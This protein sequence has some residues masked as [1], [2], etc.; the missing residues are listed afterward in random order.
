MLVETIPEIYFRSADAIPRGVTLHMVTVG[1]LADTD[2]QA[3]EQAAIS[4]QSP[5]KKRKVSIKTE[6]VEDTAE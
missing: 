5:K 3:N 6:P 4:F 1:L 2:S